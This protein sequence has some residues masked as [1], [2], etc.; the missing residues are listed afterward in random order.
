[1][2][3]VSTV[4]SKSF[5]LIFGIEKD[6]DEENQ[7]TAVITMHPPNSIR[8]ASKGEIITR[9]G[10]YVVETGSLDEISKYKEVGAFSGWPIFRFSYSTD[11]SPELNDR[12]LKFA[13][14]MEEMLK[15]Y[16]PMPEI[17]IKSREKKWWKRLLGMR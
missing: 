15:E 6:P 7:Y 9:I 2:E 16:V 12:D 5:D 3:I 13:K 4:P 1:M 14:W 11:Q 10:R 8:K 17:K